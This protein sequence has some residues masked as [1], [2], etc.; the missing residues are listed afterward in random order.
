MPVT[1]IE[2]LRDPEDVCVSVKTDEDEGNAGDGLELELADP[3]TVAV[4]DCAITPPSDKAAATRRALII[5]I[6][7]QCEEYD[8]RLWEG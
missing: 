6:L 5:R 8:I 3:E 2:V 7:I 4:G 1:E